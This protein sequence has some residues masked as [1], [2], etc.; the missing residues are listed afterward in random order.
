MKSFLLAVVTFLL[1]ANTFAQQPPQGG[2]VVRMNPQTGEQMM[3]QMPFNQGTPQPQLQAMVQVPQLQWYPIP[4][5][6]VFYPQYAY[7][8]A[9]QC[10]IYY[11]YR[12]YFSWGRWWWTYVPTWY[13]GYN[14]YYQYRP[15]YNWFWGGFYY[16]FYSY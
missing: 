14:N 4:Q 2:Y 9:P 13:C 6:Q 15:V 16:Y 10:Q 3:V 8:M 7:P 1:S 12:S 5:Q 11:V